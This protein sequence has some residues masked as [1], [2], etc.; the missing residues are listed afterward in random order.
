MPSTLLLA[1]LITGIVATLRRHDALV[2]WRQQLIAQAGGERWPDWDASRP[3]LPPWRAINQRHVPRFE[4]VYAFA[5]SHEQVLRYIP[6]VC[7]CGRLGHESVLDCFI[8]GRDSA[9]RPVWN[10]HGLTCVACVNIVRDVMLMTRIGMDIAEIR[11]A[12][13]SHYDRWLVAATP[14][15][16]PHR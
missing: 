12:I 4:G 8:R 16:V 13:D 14:T 10:D 2:K 11:S 7:G 6:C 9:G 5:A 15:E 3:A 1:V